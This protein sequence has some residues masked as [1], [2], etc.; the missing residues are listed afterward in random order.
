MNDS[1]NLATIMAQELRIEA[2]QKHIDELNRMYS[3]SKQG[4]IQDGL[5]SKLETQMK[6]N[7]Q[8]VAFIAAY[9]LW[10]EGDIKQSQGNEWNIKLGVE[11]PIS[12]TLIDTLEKWNELKQ[13]HGLAKGGE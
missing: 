13:Q 4:E 12:E 7:A 1:D 11:P 5:I 6:T 8:M 10:L 9:E 2:L 3:D